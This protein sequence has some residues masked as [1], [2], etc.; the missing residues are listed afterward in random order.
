MV[1]HEQNPDKIASASSELCG[2]SADACAAPCTESAGSMSVPPTP[3]QHKLPGKRILVFPSTL[4]GVGGVSYREAE[5]RQGYDMGIHPSPWGSA[6]PR[7][8]WPNLHSGR[9]ANRPSRI[10]RVFELQKST[11]FSKRYIS[12]FKQAHGRRLIPL[13]SSAHDLSS[14]IMHHDLASETLKL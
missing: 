6:N 13:Y 5:K 12:T 11:Y 9:L 1:G 3:R 10:W 7:G 14:H 4:L 2:A 8:D